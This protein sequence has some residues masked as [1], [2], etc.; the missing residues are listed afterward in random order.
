MAPIH[1]AEGSSA[2]YWGRYI[3][4]GEI[5]EGRSTCKDGAILLGIELV[6]CGED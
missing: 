3:R 5:G 2:I 1:M 4:E 6:V